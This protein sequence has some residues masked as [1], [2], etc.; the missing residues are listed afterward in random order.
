MSVAKSS[1]LRH[2]VSC[3]VCAESIA[4]ESGR[5]LKIVSCA[6]VMN[7]SRF[8]PRSKANQ[9][10]F[11]DVNSGN[12][13]KRDRSTRVMCLFLLRC[14]SHN[15]HRRCWGSFQSACH[16]SRNSCVHNAS[17]NFCQFSRCR[18]CDSDT[19]A[20]VCVGRDRTDIRDR[21]LAEWVLKFRYV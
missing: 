2:S 15:R 17:G 10:I 11:S 18:P 12:K 9:Q 13:K 4:Y 20:R 19:L 3:S 8:Q 7:S 14:R 16:L 5:P 1:A 21:I 6:E